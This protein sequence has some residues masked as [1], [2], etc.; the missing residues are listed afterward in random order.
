LNTGF[1]ILLTH[2]VSLNFV[3]RAAARFPVREEDRNQERSDKGEDD[4]EGDNDPD[5]AFERGEGRVG[6]S[7]FI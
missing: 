6:R 2:P 3:F 5:G 1:G 4:E 7:L